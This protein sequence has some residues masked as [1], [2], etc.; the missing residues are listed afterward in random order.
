[1]STRTERE[2]L[3]RILAGI[4]IAADQHGAACAAQASWR[5]HIEGEPSLHDLIE[6]R[7]E[8]FVAVYR[9]ALKAASVLSI[10]LDALDEALLELRGDT[11]RGEAGD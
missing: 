6:A 3:T 4:V 1:M 2:Q 8:T 9:H 11:G 5:G 7:G 10:S